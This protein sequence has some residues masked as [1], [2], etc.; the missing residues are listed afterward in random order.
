MKRLLSLVCALCLAASLC[1]C[2]TTPPA[3][4]P[5]AGVSTPPAASSVPAPEQPEPE[6]VLLVGYGRVD[7]TPEKPVAM[8]HICDALRPIKG[9]LPD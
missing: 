1:A 2:G 3:A 4:A 6:P 5:S 7:I 9:D 8:P